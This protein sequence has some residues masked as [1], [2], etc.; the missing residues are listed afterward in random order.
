M[1][2]P[3]GSRGVAASCLGRRRAYATSTT[4]PRPFDPGFSKTSVV[5]RASLIDLN[6]ALDIADK[7]LGVVGTPSIEISASPTATMPVSAANLLT[8]A[9]VVVSLVNTRSS[10]PFDALV[11]YLLQGFR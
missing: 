10:A 2:Y 9:T 11:L 7:I 8:S 3:R 1:E 5:S 4:W 6:L